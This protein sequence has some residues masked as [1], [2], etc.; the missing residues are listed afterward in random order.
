MGVVT[1]TLGPIDELA[2]APPQEDALLLTSEE[3]ASPHMLGRT[4]GGRDVRISL[5]RGQELDEGEVLLIDGQC[6]VVVRAAPE[7]LFVVRAGSPIDWAIA[8][9]QLGNFHRPVRFTDD[10]MLTP[11]DP[12]V[13]DVLT[14]LGFSFERRTMPF[15]GRRV[16]AY[17]A[18]H[19]DH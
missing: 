2:D 13:A 9:Y 6:A 3:R 1:E 19:H 5:P 15:A 12:M 4:Q 7:E 8:G 18:H 11:V 10:A 16:G 14:R 17:G